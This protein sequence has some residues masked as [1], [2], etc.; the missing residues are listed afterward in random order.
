MQ[1]K[2]MQSGRLEEVLNHKSKS[3]EEV[4]LLKIQSQQYEGQLVTTAVQIGTI[5]D[6]IKRLG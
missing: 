2:L 3:D 5:S 4:K 6:E 1:E